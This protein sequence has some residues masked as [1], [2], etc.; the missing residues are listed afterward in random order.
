MNMIKK[1][2]AAALLTAVSLPASLLAQTAARENYLQRYQLLTSKLGVDG[3]G[4]ET[5]LNHWADDYPDDTD[6]LLGRFSYYLAKSRSNSVK[7]LDQEKYLGDAPALTLKDS[8]GNDV[9][10]FTVTDYDDEIF[11]KSS[12]AIDKAIELNPDRLDLRLFKISALMAYEKESPDMAL[13]NLN[14]L[15]DYNGQ[16]HPQWV[17]PGLEADD[18]L[19]TTAVQEYCFSF[20]R[21]GT[22][23]AYESFKSL[24]EKMLNYYPDNPQFLTNIGSYH[25]VFK[26]D[27][28]TALKYYNKVLKKNP[29]YYA[30]IKNC[31]LLARNSKDVKLEKKYLAMLA[32]VTDDETEKASAEARLKAL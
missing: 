9:N 29:D 16:K 6:M 4:V 24:S 10:Y 31:V 25:F 14:G 19:F 27:N 30:A 13:S 8:L 21:I 32:R 15:I 7:V 3:V 22:P 11:G 12:Q 5:L 20:Y 26:H 17:Y 28:K 2:I 23:S 1:I 18:E